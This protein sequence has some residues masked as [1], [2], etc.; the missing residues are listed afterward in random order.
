M[1]DLD[2]LLPSVAAA[3]TVAVPT[4]SAVTTPLS[5]TLAAVPLTD[6]S[7]LAFVGLPKSVAVSSA[8]LPTGRESV[9]GLNVTPVA[10]C[11]TVTMRE[12]EYSPSAVATSMKVVPGA[13]GVTTPRTL[14]TATAGLPLRHVTDSSVAS[15][16]STAACSVSVLPMFNS[17]FDASSVM[18]TPVTFCRTR[19]TQVAT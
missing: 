10:S 4:A 3:V 8:V 5:L 1:Q 15:S 16:D 14:T 17:K 6:H 7:M 2:T 12:S 13:T 9:A 11:L 18:L 19:T